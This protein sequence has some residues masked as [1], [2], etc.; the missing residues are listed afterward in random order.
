MTVDVVGSGDPLVLI[1][2]LAT[3]RSIWRHVAPLLAASRQV[4][5]LDVPGFGSARPAGSGFD[6]AVVADQIA[7][8]LQAAGVCAPYDLVGTRWAGRSP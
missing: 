4:V 7:Q 2:G 6:L 1:C 3:T 5:T 8:D